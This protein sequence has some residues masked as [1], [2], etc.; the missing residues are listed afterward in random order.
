MLKSQI[1]WF[2]EHRDILESDL[3]HGRRA[4]GRDVDWML[5]VNPRL[6]EKGML[7]VYNPL[8]ESVSR[9]LK[10]N[11]YYTGISDA[12]LIREQEGTPQRFELDRDYSVE[13]TVEIP[14]NGSS[15]FTIEEDR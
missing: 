14:A 8:N 7:V 9:T 2:L 15:W 13:I 12:A 6:N 10:V 5:H 3:I 1:D 11:L 4:D